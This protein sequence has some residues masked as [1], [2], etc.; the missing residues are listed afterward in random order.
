MNF[1]V[2]P[3]NPY[4]ID[5]PETL[6]LIDEHK[7]ELIVFGKSMFL[8]REP[9]AEVRK[10]LDATGC[11]AVVMYDMAHVLGLIGPHFQ[12]PFQEGADLVTG[13]THKT[14]FGTQR[15]VVGSRYQEHEERY[16]LWEAIRRR[17]FPGAV[18]NHHLGTLLGLLMAAYEMNHFKK[19]YQP[20]VPANAKA[21]ARSLKE[22]GLR[23]GGRSGHRLHGNPPGG[24]E[25]RLR[26][27]GGSGASLLEQNNII[28]NYQATPDDEGFTSSGAIRLGVSEMTRFGM[29]AADFATLAHLMKEAVMD[30]KHVADQV[31]AL[32][33]PFR[34]LRYCFRG[35]ECADLVSK[36][37]ELI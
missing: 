1:P 11:D 23:R 17:S 3:D 25:R 31:K 14:F 33:V 27:G 28:C 10:Y 16:E 22:C 20:K 29:E 2:L 5:V 32:R 30:G 37:H 7:P 6:K 26:A 36:L 18:S 12:R 21:F 8:H 34:E 9:V 19:E 35:D 15:G 13:S 24:R 4:K